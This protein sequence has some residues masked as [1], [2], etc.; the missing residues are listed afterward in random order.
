MDYALSLHYSELIDH[1]DNIYS[2]DVEIAISTSYI[3]LQIAIDS[4]GRLIMQL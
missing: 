1:V 3:E 4:E 2:T